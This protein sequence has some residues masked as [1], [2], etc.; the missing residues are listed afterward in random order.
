MFD[1]RPVPE[2]DVE[3]VHRMRTERVGD[4]S[5]GTIRKWYREAPELFV[6]AYDGG[7]L[8]GF[9]LGREREEGEVEVDGIAVGRSHLR[10]GIGTALLSAFDTPGD[11]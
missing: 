2:A 3:A 5:L 9:C 1:V 4:V 11:E 8:V 7:D 6:G 10:R